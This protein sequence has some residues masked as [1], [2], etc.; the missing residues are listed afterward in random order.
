[1]DAKEAFLASE[2]ARRDRQRQDVRDIG[3][4]IKDACKHAQTRCV[5]A[6]RWR[7]SGALDLFLTTNPSYVLTCGCA[8][9]GWLHRFVCPG[10]QYISWD[11]RH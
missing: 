1:M 7:R 2:Q 4:Y 3:E 10:R 9:R 11:I 8:S 6:D 5:V